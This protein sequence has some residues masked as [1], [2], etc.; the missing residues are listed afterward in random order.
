MST[1]NEIVRGLAGRSA[2]AGRRH[3]FGHHD[4]GALRRPLAIVPISP[5][6]S[7]WGTPTD[8][9]GERTRLAKLQ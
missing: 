5:L 4:A 1:L 8:I 9:L 2:L 7:L 3:L 6:S